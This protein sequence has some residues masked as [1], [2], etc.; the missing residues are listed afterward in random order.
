MRFKG[1]G[2]RLVVWSVSLLCLLFLVSGCGQ[3]GSDSGGDSSD[4][5]QTAG[6]PYALYNQVQMGQT[7]EQVDATLGVKPEELASF[8][9]IYT[10]KDGYGVAVGYSD[11]LSKT[12]TPVVITKM[13]YGTKATLYMNAVGKKNEVTDDQVAK[14]TEG[15]TYAEVKAIL[16]SDG[17]ESSAADNFD[18]TLKITR[19]WLKDGVISGVA[20]N[21]HGADDNGIVE[22]VVS[23]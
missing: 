14:I 5:T 21:F 18:G 10:D 23:L 13:I 6:D 12:N 20:V 1:Y 22:M 17:I 15:M 4:T 11:I 7:K 3:S 19:L 2:L 9:Y 16:G 8:S